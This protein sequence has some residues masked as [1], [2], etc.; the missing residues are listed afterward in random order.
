MG[1]QKSLHAGAAS[2]LLLAGM[3][4]A[5]IAGWLARA[6][7]QRFTKT[8]LTSPAGL[9]REIAAIRRQGFAEGWDERNSGGAGVAA[10]LFGPSGALLGAL[11]AAIPTRRYGADLKRRT[12]ALVTE[13]AAA[14]SRHLGAPPDAQ[15]GSRP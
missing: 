11:S 12:R 4:D 14:I 8:T 13:S 5:E 3:S 2:K 15:L 10:P 6:D 9:K 1:E 7:L